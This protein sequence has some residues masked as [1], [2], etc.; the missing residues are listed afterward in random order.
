MWDD[1][2]KE[3]GSAALLARDELARL[4]QRSDRN[5]LLRLAGHLA[6]MGGTG[7][8]YGVAVER[9]G[10]LLGWATAIPFGFTLV[11]MFAAMHESIHRTAFKSRWLNDGVAWFAG[12]LSFYNSSFYRHYHGWHHRFAQL[13][14][15]DPELDDPKPTGLLSYALELSGATWWAGKL[16]TH[17]RCALGRLAGYGF[18]DEHTRPAVIRS[19][20]LQLAAYALAVGGSIAAGRPWF[21]VYWLLP[22]AAAQPLLRAILLAEHTGCSEDDNPLTNT[23]TTHTI[24]AVRFLMWQMP[25]HAEH[26]RYPALPFF[27]LASAHR[28]LGPHL[29]HVARNGYIGVHAQLLRSMVGRP[30]PKPAS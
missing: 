25:Y 8:L 14:G 23:R 26:H 20:R 3:G 24:L 12:L 30:R 17:V 21:L 9:A 2:S 18:L 27:A 11:T 28:A 29:A 4:Q 19:V 16:Q 6:L 7:F 1:D 15:R 5:G 13:R 10:S 22:L